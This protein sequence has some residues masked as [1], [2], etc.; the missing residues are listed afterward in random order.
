MGKRMLK[1]K[2]SSDRESVTLG[3]VSIAFF[4]ITIKFVFSGLDL[5][6]IGLGKVN[7]ISISEYA[8]SF[9]AV[10]AVWLGREWV[11]RSGT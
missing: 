9:A 11:K 5:S 3:F 1:M 7:A 4:I 10:L 6:G 2:D 8:T